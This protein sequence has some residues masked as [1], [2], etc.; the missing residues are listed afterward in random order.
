MAAIGFKTS[1]E[2]QNDSGLGYKKNWMESWNVCL[3]LDIFF[4]FA[5]RT[6]DSHLL[7]IL[8]A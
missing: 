3:L 1:N 4:I 6:L 2:P 8:V 7:A 5:A